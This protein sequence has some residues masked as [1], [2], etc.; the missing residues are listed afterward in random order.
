MKDNNVKKFSN[1]V[2]VRNTTILASFIIG[3]AITIAGFIVPPLGVIDNSVL[4]VL[5]QSLTFVAAGL[6]IK[7]WTDIQNTKIDNLINKKNS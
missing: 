6:S 1:T 4:I 7:G 3:W 2:S 5:G